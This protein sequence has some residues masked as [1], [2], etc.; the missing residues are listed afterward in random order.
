V[1]RIPRAQGPELVDPVLQTTAGPLAPILGAPSIEGLGT[2]FAGYVV[3]A[4]PPDAN[5]AVGPNHIVQAVNTDYVVFDKS[6]TVLQI[7]ISPQALWPIFT[8]PCG[9]TDDGDPIVSYDKAADRWIITQI[10]YALAPYGYGYAE[11]IAVSTTGDPTGAYNLYQLSLPNLPDYPKLAV[12]PDAYYMTFNSF[13]PVGFGWQFVGGLTCALDR[14]Q[15]L[16]GL[17]ATAICF[18][19]S[20]SY[21]GLLPSDLDGATDPPFGAPN[22]FMNLG[23][24]SLNLW[25]FHV[26]FATAGNSTLTGP[27]N[28]PVASFTDACNDGGTCIPQPGTSQQLDSLGDRLMYRLAYRNFGSY[29]ALVATH[30]VSATGG[31]GKKGRGNHTPEI[32][33]KAKGGGG[34]PPATSTQT[35]ARWYE[36]HLASGTPSVFQQGTY[37]PDSDSRWMGSIA[38]DRSGNIALG[39][40]VS[41]SSTKPAIRYTG[42]ETGDPLGQLQAEQTIVSGGGSQ[43]PTLNRWGDYT[44]MQIDP[45]DD[46]TFW[47]T[48][49]YLPSDGTFNWATKIA[50]FSFPSCP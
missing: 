50:S 45:V 13:T 28:L 3:T 29:E 26:D 34:P 17:P 5:I 21:G 23:S 35:A 14:D 8:L 15:M 44:S 30:S 38:M 6:G 9:L 36:I 19:L 32:P 46:C 18:Q 27:A 48:N 2:G 20:T 16:A 41:S 12:W 31:G 1:Q 42:R 33:P 37:A 11:C 25:K 47:Y 4:A 43:L 24:N 22:Y 7:P 39:Y 49:Q 40:S 10:S